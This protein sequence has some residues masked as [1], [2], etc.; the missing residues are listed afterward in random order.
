[1]RELYVK[2]INDV[3]DKKL[4]NNKEIS[5]LWKTLRPGDKAGRA[6]ILEQVK[7]KQE[8]FNKAEDRDAEDFKENVL[9]KKNK[10][11]RDSMDERFKNLKN[12]HKE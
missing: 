7:I 3:Y 12:K 1:M 8:A 6:V 4:A 10:E 5:E 9:K 2:Q 11:F